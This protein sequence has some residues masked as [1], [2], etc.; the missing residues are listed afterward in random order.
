MLKYSQVSHLTIQ[1]T[2]LILQ[3]HVIWHTHTWQG[4][5]HLWFTPQLPAMARVGRGQS[6]WPEIQS[7]TTLHCLEVSAIAGSWI[8]EQRQILNPATLIWDLGICTTGPNM[9]PWPVLHCDSLSHP[10]WLTVT[11]TLTVLIHCFPAAMC[12]PLVSHL[13][14]QKQNQNLKKYAI[15]V[16][17]Q[18]NISLFCIPGM[19]YL[20]QASF[21]KKMSLLTHSFV[22]A[23][24]PWGSPIGSASGEGLIASNWENVWVKDHMTKEEARELGGARFALFYNSFHQITNQGPK[25]TINSFWGRALSHQCTFH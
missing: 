17:F 1:I 14:L 6:R 25:R 9:Y 15:H 5:S 16:I 11:A 18:S 4:D 20:K 12:L 3:N 23:H 2:L 19:K 22:N 21:V 24:S 10:F 8:E 7:A 13:G